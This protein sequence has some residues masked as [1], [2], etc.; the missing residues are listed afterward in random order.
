MA[1]ISQAELDIMCSAKTTWIHI[2]MHV[3]HACV[4]PGGAL[5]SL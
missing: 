3:Y 1:S 5:H 4:S 2:H